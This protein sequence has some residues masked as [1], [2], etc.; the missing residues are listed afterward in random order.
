MAEYPLS[1]ERLLHELEK[2]PGIGP[3]TAQRLAF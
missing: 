1:L 3:R 2:L